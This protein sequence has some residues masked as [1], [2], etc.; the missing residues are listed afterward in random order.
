MVSQSIAFCLV[1]EHH[2]LRHILGLNVGFAPN[3]HDHRVDE[4][5]KKEVHGDATN[6]HQ[7]ALPRGFG[8]K[9]PRLGRLGHLFGV[10][11]LVNH[12]RNLAVTTQRKPAHAILGIAVL[13]FETKQTAT[14]FADA[15]IEEDI[16]FLNPNAEELG[17][18][19]VSTLVEQHQQR[20]CQHKLQRS[21]Y[22]YFHSY[23]LFLF[24]L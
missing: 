3:E 17:K 9:L 2:S 6:H 7:Q 12:A 14:P 21:Y 15:D 23:L 10:E 24:T 1:V 13:G 8:A 4:E 11:T 16:E 5:G 18:K 22:D 20:D 19:H